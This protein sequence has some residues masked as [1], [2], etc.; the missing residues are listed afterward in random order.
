MSTAVAVEVPPLAGERGGPPAEGWGKVSRAIKYR[1]A[2]R[3]TS[4]VKDRVVVL[5]STR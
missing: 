1:V 3:R 2:S 4:G 5:R